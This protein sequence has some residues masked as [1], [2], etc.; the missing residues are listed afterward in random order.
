MTLGPGGRG[1]NGSQTMF[2][3]PPPAPGAAPKLL[4]VK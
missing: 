1:Y 4:D 3:G 2:S